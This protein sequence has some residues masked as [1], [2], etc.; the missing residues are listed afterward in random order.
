MIP[1][2]HPIRGL[3][4]CTCAAMFMVLV[5]GSDRDAYNCG[6]QEV[7]VE[8]YKIKWEVIPRIPARTERPIG[9]WFMRLSGWCR[10]RF[11]RGYCTFLRQMLHRT[12]KDLLK[13]P[14]VAS[15]HDFDKT[16]YETPGYMIYIYEKYGSK[17]RCEL[18]WKQ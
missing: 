7:E 9:H 16:F 8:D 6:L 11:S 12:G 4:L 1:P 10:F 3:G 2:C 5:N 14:I 17:V 15:Y 13:V 18:P